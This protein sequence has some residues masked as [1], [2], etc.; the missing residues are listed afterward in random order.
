MIFVV[1]KVFAVHQ[2]QSLS[3]PDCSTLTEDD[4]I[5]AIKAV[6]GSAEGDSDYPLKELRLLLC[7]RG[8]TDRT[9]KELTPLS[10]ELD[11]LA[12]TGCY[13]LSDQA[14]SPLLKSGCYSSLTALDLS[15][16]LRLGAVGLS[17]IGELP[18]LRSLTLNDITH[19]TDADLLSL[20]DSGNNSNNSQSNTN[21][22]SSS[23]SSSSSSNPVALRAMRE[24]RHLSISGLIEVTD[25]S[26]M[27]LI[28]SCG[29]QFQSLNISGCSLLTDRTIEAI[30]LACGS[31]S[32]IDVSH[33]PELSTAA[34]IGL[35]IAHPTALTRQN[36]GLDGA[37]NGHLE[38][39]GHEDSAPPSIGRLSSVNLQGNVNT[40]DEVIIH[41]SEMAR[42]SLT[43]L[44]IS[45]C[46]RLTSLAAV[47]LKM[48]CSHSLKH[49]DVSFVRGMKEEAVGALI[50]SCPNISSL[51][52]WVRISYLKDRGTNLL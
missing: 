23:S 17:A 2:S 52:V 50:D 3:F 51:H 8:F 30:R 42:N 4:I 11:S 16:N 20:L 6:S 36:N 31:L 13:K 14:L 26:V 22:N 38:A 40:T 45:G 46:N 9:A 39:A 27:R 18:N 5:Q 37:D 15:C 25:T 41:L 10:H 21:N 33:L 7:G 19:L 1:L 24:L 34:L 48:N 28:F 12:I 49:L 35:F 44:D 29:S 32:S 47:A 43:H